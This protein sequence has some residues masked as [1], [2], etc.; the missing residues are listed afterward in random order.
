MEA[1]SPEDNQ[2]AKELYTRYRQCMEK[3]AEYSVEIEWDPKTNWHR[4]RFESQD[5]IR[6]VKRWET[7]CDATLWRAQQHYFENQAAYHGQALKEATAAGIE[8]DWP[9]EEAA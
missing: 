2:M 8:I 4:H 3:I 7:E 5:R 1:L 6:N 9:I